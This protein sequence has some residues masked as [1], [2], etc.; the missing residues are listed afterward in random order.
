M[1]AVEQLE[2]DVAVSSS[3]VDGTA[4]VAAAGHGDQCDGIPRDGTAPSEASAGSASA[5]GHC[6]AAVAGGTVAADP[7]RC[8]SAAAGSDAVAAAVGCDGGAGCSHGTRRH[9][10]TRLSGPSCQLSAAFQLLAA[11]ACQ[12]FAAAAVRLQ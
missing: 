3:T 7:S 11:V 12:L 10:D 1:A 5:A 9:C 4:A 8:R 6:A 2:P